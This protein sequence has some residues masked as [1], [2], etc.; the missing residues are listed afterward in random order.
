MRQAPRRGP[1]GCRFDAAA[2]A[3]CRGLRARGFQNGEIVRAF[4]GVAERAQGR[5]DRVPAAAALLIVDEPTAIAAYEKAGFARE[6]LLRAAA[7]IDGQW[8]DVV[9]MGLIR[10]D[11]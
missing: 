1:D 5:L 9:P 7:H 10:D 11:D 3:V 4:D 8:V 2:V 6:G